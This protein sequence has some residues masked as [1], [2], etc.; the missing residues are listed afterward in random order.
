MSIS[1][2][3]IT[4]TDTTDLGQL[5]VYLT[6]ST[7]RQ[8]IYDAGDNP[9]TTATYYPDWSTQGNALIITPHV[10]FNG[11]SQP[12]NSNKIEVAWSKEEGGI[13]YPNQSVPIFPTSPTTEACPESVVDQAS[14]YKKIQ[15]PANLTINSTGASYT[16]TITYYPIDGDRTVTLQAIATLDLT[17]SNNGVDGADGSQGA[18]AKALQLVGTGNYFTYHYEGTLFGAP[19]ITLTSQSQNISGIHWYCDNKAIKIINNKK[20]T[21]DTLPGY[22]SA[23]YYT[24]TSLTIAGNNTTEDSWIQDLAPNFRAN[25]S[26]Q[27]K[28]V[29]TDSNGNEVSA[30]NGLIDYMS[31]YGLTEAAPG[32]DTYSASLSNDEETI[33]DYEGTPILDNANTELFI[34]QGGVDDL[35]NWHIAVTD[36]IGDSQK[37]NYELTNSKDTTGSSTNLNKYGPDRV[38]VTVMNTNVLNAAK[39]TFTA[40]HGT[41]SGNEFTP[42]GEVSNIIKEFSLVK[43][44]ALVSHSLRLDSVNAN[45]AA[46]SNTYIPSVITVDAIT[47]RGGSTQPYRDAG[48]IK[49]K[50]YYT[51]GTAKE[52]YEQNSNENPLTLT[53]STLVGSKVISYI[54]TFLGGTAGESYSDAEDKQKI[55]ISVNGTNGTDGRPGDS[56]WNFI[57][58]NSFDA[59]STDFSNRTSQAFVINI[60]IQAVE[61]VTNRT[62]YKTGSTT[63]PTVYGAD[64]TYTTSQGT[65]GTISA[66]YYNGEVEVTTIGEVDNIR[67]EIPAGTNIGGSDSSTIAT[68][69]IVLTLTYKANTSLSQTY[70]YKAQPEALKPIRVLLES[71]PSDTFE[72]QEGTITVTPLVMSGTSP[73]ASSIWGSPTWKVYTTK[74]NV[75]D[76]YTISDAGISGVTVSNN[77]LSVDGTAVQGYLGFSFTVSITRGGITETYTEYINLKDI[78][79]PLQVSLHST[80]GEQIVNGQGIGVIYTRVI[81]RGDDEDYDTIVPDNMLAVGTT[82]PTASTASGKTGYCYVVL[83]NNNPA[84]PTGEVRY[85]W[86]DSGSGN[87]SG[88]RGTTT[89][90][91]KYTYTWYFRDSNN[92]AYVYND[93]STPT[94]LNY[95]LETN[96]STHKPTHNQQFV[97]IDSSVINNKITAVAKVEI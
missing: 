81:R 64:L 58:R 79:D 42:D 90:P 72:N 18:P 89:N 23:P 54:D 19:T 11:Q 73:V 3:T 86:R 39:I 1:Y 13:M 9:P 4:I 93:A 70:T 30:P 2:G 84:K 53:L 85:Y 97:Y 48:V 16:A 78:D 95:L 66:K 36:S 37:F 7:V 92:G 24:E 67:Y 20:V 75:T 63:Y 15:R 29:E 91:Y 38:K 31:I 83:D 46:D 33:V 59:I 25:K 34:S 21:D 40:V 56:P 96:S 60:P 32:T 26:A 8:Q 41:Y 50:V 55:T 87:W 62:I 17:I 76:W 71:N 45:K 65:T 68:G 80:V 51:D 6:G 14:G 49:A 57:L 35:E 28:I 52:G 22:N 44:S 61:G 88:P 94:V 10:Y 77:I 43:S 74:N 69:S 12:L 27:F 47:R 82:A 5:S